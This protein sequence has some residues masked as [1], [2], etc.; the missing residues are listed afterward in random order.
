MT[1]SISTKTIG[2]H[3]RGVKFED[4]QNILKQFVT[5]IQFRTTN[6]FLFIPNYENKKADLKFLL[7]GFWLLRKNSNYLQ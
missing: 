3:W 5:V 1:R 4:Q 7:D 2:V 6:D